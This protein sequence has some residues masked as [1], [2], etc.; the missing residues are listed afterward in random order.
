MKTKPVLFFAASL[1]SRILFCQTFP[2]YKERSFI[3]F[4]DSLLLNSRL[5]EI[6]EAAT[7]GSIDPHE[8]IAGP[9]DKIFISISGVEEI[10]FT[11]T[12]NQEGILYIPKVGAVDLKDKILA[13]AKEKIEKTINRYYK[14]VGVFISLVGFR[15][16]RVSL[17]GNVKKPSSFTLPGNSRLLDLITASSG[18]SETANFRNINIKDRSGKEGSFDLIKFF[19]FGDRSQNP[20]L[21]EGNIVLVDKVDKI[22]SIS[23]Q[24]K[25][26]GAYEFVDGESVFD[27]I[28]ISGGILARARE[29]SIEVVRFEANGKDQKSMYYS[30]GQLEQ[31]QVKL[32][33]GDLVLIRELPDY[34]IDKSVKIEGYVKYPGYYKIVEDKTTLSQI[35]KEAG[36]FRE[37]ASLTEASLVR[38]KGISGEDPE[39]ERLKIIPRENMTEDEYDY[40]KAKSRQ[41]IGK[42]VVDF[43]EL[44][45]NTNISEDV[46]LKREDVITVPEAKN[47]IILLGQVVNPGNII[48]KEGLSVDDYIQLAGGFG[49]RAVESEVRVIKAKTKEWVY[50]DEVSSLEPGDTIWIPEETP[51]PKFWEVFT[52][53]LTVLGQ[54]AA[55]VAATAAVIIATR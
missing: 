9:G 51:G 33:F 31:E 54:L 49:W 1:F 25:F 8:Y 45:V 39:F 37:N 43:N 47:Y 6:Q 22:V 42:V 18:L 55:V 26:P 53:I 24:V 30:L 41:H 7:E 12:V 35:V 13:E 46:T 19:R 23:G 32:R 20:L 17:V 11:L 36:G 15:N 28:K 44:F 34:F 48:F 5:G 29:D 14:N 21:K 52:D 16:I 40:F 27:L 50:A 4:S 3:D 10:S 2:D 38:S